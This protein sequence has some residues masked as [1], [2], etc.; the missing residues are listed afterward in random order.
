MNF[1]YERLLS[2]FLSLEGQANE[3]WISV[4]NPHRDPVK[5]VRQ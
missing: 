3:Y 1:V 2:P 4:F 5:E